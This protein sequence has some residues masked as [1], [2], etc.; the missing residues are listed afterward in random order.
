MWAQLLT[1]AFLL[2]VGGGAFAQE[3]PHLVASDIARI[4]GW[5]GDHA[6]YFQRPGGVFGA[7][8]TSK[9]LP[10]MTLTL[11]DIYSKAQK[12]LQL[13]DR[14]TR[15][16]ACSRDGRW[17]ITEHGAEWRIRVGDN[18]CQSQVPLE[19]PTVTLWDTRDNKHYIL[20]QGI[21]SLEW[22]PDG[23]NLLY[24]FL[25][26]CDLDRDSRNSFRLPP[27]INEFLVVPV[28]GAVSQIPK[29][30][31][32]WPGKI[33]IEKVS[34]LDNDR[35]VM[36]LP[37]GNGEPV[38]LWFGAVVVVHLNEGT[39]TD[40]YQL[41]PRGFQSSR[42]LNVPQIKSQE[43]TDMLTSANCVVDS[44]SGAYLVCS[45]RDRAVEQPLNLDQARYC[46]ALAAG[47][48][49]EL[50]NPAKRFWS[51]SIIRR[52]G[53]VLLQR[54][55]VEGSNDLFRIENDNGGYLK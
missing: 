33:S 39:A 54:M 21:M 32:G 5:C 38:P 14:W 18:E 35:F 46:Q 29:L 15:V 41:N 11:L 50:C 40:I 48:I 47:D 45:N 13:D 19:L 7:T 30:G 23:K 37:G 53:E 34:W 20:G 43:S 51:A 17:V 31:S 55:S 10:R 2:G 1:V 22:S 16:T 8:D 26:E 44:S 52:G 6:V 27:Q 9:M 4:D 3:V 12:K 28:S 42:I 49:E 36:Q 24:H 25:P